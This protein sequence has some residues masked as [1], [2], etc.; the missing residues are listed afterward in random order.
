MKTMPLLC[1]KCFDCRLSIKIVAPLVLSIFCRPTY[2]VTLDELIANLKHQSPLTEIAKL[3]T[4]SA[5]LALK[6]LDYD[7]SPQL[8]ASSSVSNDRTET[9]GKSSSS[10]GP[11][12]NIAGSLLIP[13]EKGTKLSIAAGHQHL[14]EEDSQGRKDG[15]SWGVKI[16]QPFLKDAMGKDATLRREN[17]NWDFVSK[18]LSLQQEQANLIYKIELA[19]WDI[20]SYIKQRNI[21]EQNLQRR[22]SLVKWTRQRVKNFAA[23]KSDLL[24]IESTLAQINL[25]LLANQ[26][27][28]RNAI[29]RLSGLLPQIRVNW[30]EQSTAELEKPRDI[31]SIPDQLR[32]YDWPMTS[33]AP[34]KFETVLTAIQSKKSTIAA[35]VNDNAMAPS[36][37]GFAS[38]GSGKAGTSVGE[39][40]R[41][42]AQGKG[43]TAAIG[44]ELSMALTG[45]LKDYKSKSARIQSQSLNLRMQEQQRQ[46][47]VEWADLSL[48]IKSLTEQLEATKQLAKLQN[49]KVAAERIRYEQGRTTALQ[50]T[51]FELDAADSDLKY[52]QILA[53]LRKAE[54]TARQFV[55]LAKG[56]P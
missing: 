47:A 22:Q 14:M 32:N 17:A 34:T 39:T 16:S 51:T 28:T 42:T 6:S 44:V 43:P 23:E 13:F 18:E 37:D 40:W 11:T 53:D 12:G 10:L 8:K 15:A 55:R 3:D 4:E 45:D 48:K 38:Y 20:L 30:S 2:A 50:M 49:Q 25:S 9:L 7:L 19:Y 5:S 36:L 54:A 35:D 52:C 41:D 29:S 21:I 46:S 24:Q 33:D 56:T 31:S 27:S 26:E 1:I